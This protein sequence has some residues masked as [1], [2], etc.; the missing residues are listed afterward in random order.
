M[1]PRKVRAD[2]FFFSCIVKRTFHVAADEYINTEPF[3]TW[4]PETA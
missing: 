1:Q 3:P 2:P 4:V